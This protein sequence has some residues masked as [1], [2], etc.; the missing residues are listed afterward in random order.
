MVSPRIRVRLCEALFSGVIALLLAAGMAYRCHAQTVA[1]ADVSGIVADQS[2]S[3]VPGATV[4]M[5]QTDKEFVRT[6]VTDSE[7]RYVVPNLP[8]GP[9]RLEVRA[10]GF[11]DYSQSG[12]VLQVGRNVQQNVS[13]QVGAPAETVEVVA[14]AGMVETTQNG[15]GQVIDERRINNLPLQAARLMARLTFSTAAIIQTR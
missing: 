4:R 10:A 2:G 8:V 7:G 15:V 3:A 14:A 9:Y 11:K 13:L 5:V 12:I 1:V 6:A